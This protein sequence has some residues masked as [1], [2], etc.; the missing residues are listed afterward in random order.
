MR[1]GV[2][3]KPVPPAPALDPESLRIDRTGTSVLHGVDA[4]AVETA[5]RLRDDVG[6]EVV[7]VA[8]VPAEATDALR[9]GLAMGA[10][11]AVV[12]TSDDLAGSD[13][14]VTSNVLAQALRSLEVDLVLLGASSGE[15]NGALLW[16]A[17]AERLGMP[18]LSRA[19]EVSVEGG[20]VRAK[21][22]MEAGFDEAET[23]LPAVLALSGEICVP[24]YPSFKDVVAAKRKPVDVLTPEE[25]GLPSSALGLA[26][27]RTRVLAVGPVP[28]RKRGEIVEDD[29]HAHE[30]V[31]AFLR[32]RG[33]A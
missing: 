8:M 7:L 21:R 18:V 3:V 19:V 28:W 17:L 27:S 4:S 22:Q 14:V 26:G 11:R 24:R 29:G 6:G 20:R 10:D 5:L 15:G 16:S 2:C 32:H 25:L 1:I 33:L 23:A 13:L 31:V 12:V 30:R 9:S